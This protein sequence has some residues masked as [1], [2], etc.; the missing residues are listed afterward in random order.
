[1]AQL[2]PFF[3]TAI[4]TLLLT[5]S[6]L[7]SSSLQPTPK[8]NTR[9]RFLAKTAASIAAFE[10][11]TGGGVRTVNAAIDVSGL[12]VEGGSSSR[13]PSSGGARGV[14]PSELKIGPPSNSPLGFQVGGGPRS[15]EVVRSIDA[16]RYD[17]VRRA[18]GLPPKFLEGVPVEA[19]PEAIQTDLEGKQATQ[20][21]RTSKYVEQEIELFGR[22]LM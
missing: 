10:I 13:Q 6:P 18:Q 14:S 4:L 1:M 2:T 12:P 22:Y 7:D 16:P 15:E 3:G 11:T 9:R 5:L 20:Q 17:A 21:P 19:R 8:I